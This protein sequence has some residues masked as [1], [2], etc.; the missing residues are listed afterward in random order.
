M[1]L[2]EIDDMAEAVEQHTAI[3]DALVAGQSDLAA[4]LVEAHIRT[5]DEQIR[6]AVR[7]R[8]ESPLSGW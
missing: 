7:R 8:L 1:Y 2:A 5:F 6:A 4:A 3:L